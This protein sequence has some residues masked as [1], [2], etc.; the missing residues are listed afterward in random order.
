[1]EHVSATEAKNNLGEV[2]NKALKAPIIIERNGKPAVVM[3]P[4]E[5][6]LSKNSKLATTQDFL[7]YCNKLR[8]KSIKKGMTEKIL[9]S[10][11]SDRK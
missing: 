2:I 4:Y 1:M 3:L 6:Y 10:I 5:T 8:R 7:D 9:K 11:L